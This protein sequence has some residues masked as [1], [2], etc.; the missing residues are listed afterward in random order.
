M[1]KTAKTTIE[2]TVVESVATVKG[3]KVNPDST[4]QKRLNERAAK[5]TVIKGRPVKAESARQKRLAELSAKRESGE[6][7]KGRPVSGESARQKRIAER[8]M[9]AQAGTLKKGRPAKAKEVSDVVE[10]EKGEVVEAIVEEVV[11]KPKRVAKK[12]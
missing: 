4:R 6:L 1:K 12:K 9:K 8:E 11:T 10:L 3:R 2:T 7:K 5:G